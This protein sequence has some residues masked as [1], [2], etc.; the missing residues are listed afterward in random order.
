MIALV[1]NTSKPDAVS[2]ASELSELLRQK[3]EVLLL[4]TAPLGPALHDARPEVVVV[5][6]GDGSILSVAH[7]LA[8]VPAR[9]VG[10][11]F[12]KLGYL[13]EFTMESLLRHWE[14]IYSGHAP[15]SHRLMLKMAIYARHDWH[16]QKMLAVGPPK[17]SGLALNDVVLHAGPPYRIIDLDLLI[18]GRRITSFRSDGVVIATASGSTGYNL[19]A[20][21]PILDPDIQAMLVTPICAH[22]LSF[23][24]V[25][26]SDR[27]VVCIQPREVN[28]GTVV[29]LDGQAHVPLER[30]DVLVVKRYEHKLSLVGNPDLD[31]WQML[32]GKLH[33]ARPAGE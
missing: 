6:G 12:G 26:V 14:A 22:S 25:A 33:W 28:E 2:A 11:N 1:P 24:P 3:H 16:E 7:D 29:S 4:D 20:G 18:N 17:F 9:V 21:G 19:S 23:R 13:A 27:S 5:L 30:G 15:V 32:A 31:H 8:G 10:I